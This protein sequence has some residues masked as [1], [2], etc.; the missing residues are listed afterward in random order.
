[1]ILSGGVP[2]KV[3]MLA[4]SREFILRL[5]ESALHVFSTLSEAVDLAQADCS[6]YLMPATLNFPA[7]DCLLSPKLLL[8]VGRNICCATV[9]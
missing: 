5:P 6:V 8:Q 2:L 1:M 4:D 3:K 9:Q 7:I